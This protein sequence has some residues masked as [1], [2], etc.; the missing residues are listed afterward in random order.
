MK[1]F[2][3]FILLLFTLNT[4]SQLNSF[5]S[6]YQTSDSTKVDE[7]IYDAFNSQIIYN[8]N[9]YIDYRTIHSKLWNIYYDSIQINNNVPITVGWL[10][11]NKKL[12]FSNI[13]TIPLTF[14]QISSGLG[15]TPYNTTNPNG[16]ISGVNSSMITTALGFTPISI[17]GARV[18][19]S[20]TTTGTG[21]ASYNSSTGVLNVP[22]YTP[23]KRTEVYS[24]TT[25]ASGVYTVTFPVAFSVAPNIQAS[26]TN[27]GS[28]N[29]YLRVSNIST[30]G[31]TINA[32]SF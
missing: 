1:K 22:N 9:T 26:I 21:A 28:T 16:Y 3:T 27:Q 5:Y 24:G 4:Y 8:M 25:N 14:S 30:T 15:Y 31:F 17:G 7:W 6:S 29:Q 2:A 11:L 20:L 10:D 13:N 23:T 19:L 18:A 32:Y 12:N